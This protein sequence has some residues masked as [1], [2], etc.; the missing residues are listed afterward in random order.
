MS[1]GTPKPARRRRRQ[2]LREKLREERAGGI[3]TD[4][5]RP[6]MTGGRFRPL[7]DRELER[8]H[9]TALDV[10]EQ[11]GIGSPTDSIVEACL[12]KGA[13]LSMGLQ[14]TAAP[15]AE[16]AWCPEVGLRL[17]L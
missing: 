14:A 8:V 6:G 11:I 13:K 12:P 5:V 1:D 4:A 9:H 17:G 2:S 15:N 16:A 3:T 10:L 7:S